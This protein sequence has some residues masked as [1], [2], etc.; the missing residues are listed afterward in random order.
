MPHLFK[1]DPYGMFFKHLQD[2]FHPKDF[3]NGFPHLFQLYFHIAQGHIP[4][5]ITHV[6]GTTRF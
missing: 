6:L 2:I 1:N 5:Q 3:V 4:Y